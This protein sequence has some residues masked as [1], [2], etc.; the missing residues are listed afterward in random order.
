MKTKEI[1]CPN[2][3]GTGQVSYMLPVMMGLCP[4]IIPM[5]RECSECNGTGKIKKEVK[6][7]DK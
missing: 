3:N 4:S 6:D 2:C 1:D 7:E 5:Y